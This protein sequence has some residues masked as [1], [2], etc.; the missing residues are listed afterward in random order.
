MSSS[1]TWKVAIVGGLVG[2]LVGGCAKPP[3]EAPKELGDLGLFLFKHFEDEDPAEMAAGLLNLRGQV[4]AM[5]L[6]AD[7]KDIAVTMPILEGDNLGGLSI[8]AGIDAELQVPIALAGESVHPIDKQPI[9]ALEPNQVCIE[10][11]TTVWAMRDFL[12]DTA[13]FED[14]SCDRLDTLQEV[15]KENF[16]AKVWFDQY[17]NY[18][19]FELEDE[20]GNVTRALVGRSWIAEQFPADGG[21]NSWDQ[22]FH[23]DVSLEAGGKTLKW[24]SMWSSVTLGGVGDDIYANLV[25]DGIA[26]AQLF[27]DE[28]IS[29]TINECTNDRN[30][31][32]PDR[33]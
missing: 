1:G 15:R 16:L 9:L 11:D 21:N 33:E 3:A 23:L 28:F 31:P 27:G 8:P 7:P 24:F 22:L 26:Q 10:S 20:E 17:K 25:I 18:R 13:C 12:S 32:K 4:Q 19:W 14:G 6:S 5:D 30:L 2:A 29:G